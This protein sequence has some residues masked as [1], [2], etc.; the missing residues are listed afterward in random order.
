MDFSFI[1]SAAD[2][3]SGLSAYF[4]L[5]FTQIHCIFHLEVTLF[6]QERLL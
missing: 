4:S 6:Y 1:K 5:I 3:D 2:A